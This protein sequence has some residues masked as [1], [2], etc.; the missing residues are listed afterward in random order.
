MN[1]EQS[2]TS[3]TISIPA[4]NDS[5]SL[6]RLIE[7]SEA[8][9]TSL[10]INFKLLVVNDGSRDDTLQVALKMKEKYG[11]ISI[12]SHP[13]N[14]GFGETLKEVFTKPDTEWVLFLPGDNQFPVANLKRFLPMVNDYDFILGYR[15]ERKDE[16]SRKLYSLIYNKLVSMLF[17]YKVR[18][19][20]SIVFYRTGILK[21]IQLQGNSAFVHAE[22][23]IK[24]SRAGFRVAE[25][26]IEHKEREFGFG[27]GGNL[28]V[29]LKTTMEL[30]RYFARKNTL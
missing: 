9:C 8:L 14:M 25:I 17:G 6:S 2:I 29:M 16:A 4:Y 5:A 28:K 30:F 11:N 21:N 7:E 27:S 3:L 18:D 22:L 15:K 1:L 23:F 19:V 10:N 24:V 12:I 26:E 13:V 20:N